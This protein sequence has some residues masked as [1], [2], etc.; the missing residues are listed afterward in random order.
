MFST[1]LTSTAWSSSTLWTAAL[2]V[3][4][5]HQF[6]TSHRAVAVDISLLQHLL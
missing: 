3:H 6:F 5:G 1:A 4:C 2:V